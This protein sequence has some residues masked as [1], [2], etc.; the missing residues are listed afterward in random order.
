MG[1]AVKQ[2]KKVPE[3]RFSAFNDEWQSAKISAVT[4]DVTYGLTVRPEYLTEG[5]PLISAREIKTGEINYDAAPKISL[6]DFNKLSD[7][8]K[9]RLGDL[10]LTK[11]GTVGFSS[12]VDRDIKAAITQN[13]AII[14]IKDEQK[15]YGLFLLQQ[16][17]TE[18]FQRK[19]LSKVNQSTIMDLQLGDI[20]KTVITYP[21]YTEQ[22]KIA[23]FL[24]SVDTWLDNLRKQK[25]TLETYKRSMMQKL[26]TQ[27]VRFK[28][29]NGKA[30]PEWISLT[31]GELGSVKTSSTDKLSIKGETS[32][33]L[34]NYMDV[35]RRDHIYLTDSFQEVTATNREIS[36]FTLKLGDVLFTPS[37]ETPTDIGHSAVVMEDLPGV[38]YSYHLV[39]FRPK[40]NVFYPQFAGYAFKSYAF[41]KEFWRRA[42][43]ATRFTLSLES[44][45]DAM[46]F[47][48]QNLDEQKKIADFLTAL[49]ETIKAKAEE[50]AKV[51]QWKKGLMQKMF[52]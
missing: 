39:R 10:F 42:Q 14:R 1:T 41:Y 2:Q 25:T 13:I 24:G 17:K 23:D 32:V 6:A 3:L 52:I 29:D 27:Q 28:D 50:I 22:Q 40:K 15:L 48:P 18:D 5:V 11:T 49:D 37:S 21:G 30:F 9:P 35:Y 31:L 47:Y 26:F 36:T 46:V 7:K 12:I 51:E 16:F 4:S 34:L 44:I 38:L 45:K 33:K 19:I 8:A 43:G 20:K